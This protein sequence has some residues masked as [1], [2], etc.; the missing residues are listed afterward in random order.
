M[1]GSVCRQCNSAAAVT[2]DGRLCL[3]CLRAVLDSQ[4]GEPVRHL[5]D[6]PN[7]GEL[8][9]RPERVF[10][11]PSSES[12]DELGLFPDWWEGRLEASDAEAPYIAPGED[13]V[14]SVQ[15]ETDARYGNCD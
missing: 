11:V 3:E 7:L 15:R 9:R 10:A 14:D 4:D 12:D 1:Q 6:C 8:D 5:Y 2:N 13:W